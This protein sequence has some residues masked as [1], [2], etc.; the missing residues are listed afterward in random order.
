MNKQVKNYRVHQNLLFRGLGG[1]FFFFFIFSLAAIDP[2]HFALL[3]DLHIAKATT[4]AEDLESSVRQINSTPT[5]EF[6][7]VTGDVTEY[8]DKVSLEKAKY[9]LDKLSVPYYITSG[10]HETKW[11]ASGHTDFAQIFGSDRFDFEHKG[12]RFF[13][14]NTGPILR[15]ADGHVLPQDITWLKT[16]LTGIDKSAPIILATHYPLQY[17]DVDNWY[18][19]TDAVRTHNIRAVLGGHYHRNA[20]FS[21]D[22]IPG[23][24]NRSNLRAKADVGGYSVYSIT[25]DSLIVYEQTIGGEP[26]R[27]AEL[28]MT[29]KYFDEPGSDTKYPD[30][31]VNKAFPKVKEKWLVE[32]GVGIYSSPVIWKNRVFVGDDLGYLTSYNLKNGKKQWSF[33]TKQRI[34]GTPAVADG[35]VVFGSADKNIYG[36]NAKTGQQIWKIQT[37]EAVLGAVTIE[38]GIAYMGGSDNTFRA[39]LIKNGTPLWEYNKLK[40]YVETKPLIAGEKVILGAWDMN[41]YALNKNYGHMVWEWTNGIKSTHYS[42]AAVWAVSSNGKVF[43][44]DPERAITAINL[45]TGETIWRTKQSMV[46]ESI[47]ISED[48]SQ[49]YAKTMQDSVVCYSTVGDVPRKI[50]SINVGYGYEHNPSML[51][52][53]DGTVYG[54]T[55]NGMIFALDAQNGMVIWKHKIGNSL[56]NTVLPIGRKQLLVTTASGEL[57]L[58]KA[59]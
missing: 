50:W 31:S 38:S 37:G 24:I 36:L 5:I 57:S 3:T 14:F 29:E 1:L 47:G 13:G 43:V 12:V 32:T 28:S 21:Y 46:R 53:K 34:V 35:I 55:K 56:V 30:F 25:A 40:G 48:G 58:L 17:G 6:V 23:L 33:Q 16:K 27:W 20:I 19:L 49:I 22:G 15:M 52:E 26:K 45:E 42:P 4:A 11:S 8:G 39:I 51:M 54:S 41:F 59:P 7:L 44:V 10:N 2:F 9:I 18:E